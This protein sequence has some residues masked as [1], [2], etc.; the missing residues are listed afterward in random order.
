MGHGATS[1]SKGFNIFTSSND[2][3]TGSI[4]ALPYQ[5][6]SQMI[7]KAES[8]LCLGVDSKDFA[9][10]FAIVPTFAKARRRHQ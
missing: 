1:R 7:H 10:I 2:E 8:G 4:T 9:E 5:Q 3:L 6:T